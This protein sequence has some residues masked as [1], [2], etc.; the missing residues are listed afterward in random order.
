MSYRSPDE[1]HADVNPKPD[2]L[3]RVGLAAKRHTGT[4]ER[5]LLSFISDPY[6]D[7]DARG[8]LTRDVLQILRRHDV[9]FQILTKAAPLPSRDFDLYRSG[10]AFAVT[11][12]T[13]DRDAAAALEPGAAPPGDRL[14][15]LAEAH[16]RGIECWVSVEPVTDIEGA[17]GVIK[18]AAKYAAVFKVGALGTS[19]V[20]DE[21]RQAATYPA[22]QWR[23]F[24]RRARD[25]C[26]ANGAGYFIKESL[27]RYLGSFEFA[28]NL[29]Q[30]DNRLANWRD[31]NEC[32]PNG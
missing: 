32:R 9:P 18:A 5:V 22:E 28:H 10:D 12:T 11:L 23:V 24:I 29:D 2:A 25:L 17:I 26:T 8:G 19:P 20:P 16:S 31:L 4:S 6:P 21:I 27:T 1:F 3:K 30:T 15:M 7:C 14:A 13:M